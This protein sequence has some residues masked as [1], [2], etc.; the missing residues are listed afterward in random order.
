MPVTRLVPSLAVNP[1]VPAMLSEGLAVWTQKGREL[2]AGG[3]EPGR[4]PGNSGRLDVRREEEG[5]CSVT[6]WRVRVCTLG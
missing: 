2:R 1:M 5:L 3:G 4:C 6:P